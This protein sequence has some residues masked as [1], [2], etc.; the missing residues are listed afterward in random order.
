LNNNKKNENADFVHVL[1]QIILE[2]GYLE[3]I[4]FA[5]VVIEKKTLTQ[6]DKKDTKL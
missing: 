6:R 4:L 2:A 1:L 5:G 3:L